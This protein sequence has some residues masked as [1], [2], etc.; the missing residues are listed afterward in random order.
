MAAVL[1]PTPAHTAQDQSPP[2]INSV[3][4]PERQPVRLP[5]SVRYAVR[6][7]HDATGQFTA[8][9]IEIPY[10][11]N[12]GN[13]TN[14]TDRTHYDAF[15]AALAPASTD[16][17]NVYSGTHIDELLEYGPAYRCAAEVRLRYADRFPVDSKLVATIFRAI[18][19]RKIANQYY[20]AQSNRPDRTTREHRELNSLFYQ[21][22]VTLRPTIVAS[23]LVAAPV[24]PT[25]ERSTAASQHGVSA[26][27][28]GV[29]SPQEALPF[30]WPRF[31]PRNTLPSSQINVTAPTSASTAS[32]VEADTNTGGAHFVPL[33]ETVRLSTQDPQLEIVPSAPQVEVLP[34]SLATSIVD[35]SQDHPYQA[36]DEVNSTLSSNTAQP[37]S[38]DVRHSAQP[39]VASLGAV[40]AQPERLLEDPRAFLE[41]CLPQF[42][43]IQLNTQPQLQ[44]HRQTLEAVL[45]HLLPELL[46]DRLGETPAVDECLQE[47]SSLLEEPNAL[48]FV[49]EPRTGP[50]SS[51]EDAPNSSAV[52]CQ[53][54][55]RMNVCASTQTE[56]SPDEASLS[57]TNATD[58]TIS[59][60]CVAQY[61]AAAPPPNSP[62]DISA[63]SRRIAARRRDHSSRL[64]TE[65]NEVISQAVQAAATPTQAPTPG[66]TIA[67]KSAIPSVT[68]PVA[69]I[70]KPQFPVATAVEPNLPS[71]PAPT[72]SAPTPRSREAPID[73]ASMTLQEVNVLYKAENDKVAAEL[74]AWGLPR[75]ET[76]EYKH[77]AQVVRNKYG[78]AVL[79]D[80][81]FETLRTSVENVIDGRQAAA[82]WYVGTEEGHQGFL[83]MMRETQAIL[84]RGP[85]R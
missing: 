53:P 20:A 24:T 62:S 8:M 16:L 64:R 6:A 29:I 83:T 21:L 2:P 79:T 19:N 71:A 65:A 45:R 57:Q 85:R 35:T 70:I 32:S 49:D 74:R 58:S 50:G 51:G 81:R 73:W 17:R 56:A 26:Q 43:L 66:T 37:V 12:L 9:L 67:G 44:G 75:L 30:A 25:I 47:L 22:T 23:L 82:R 77:L 54:T 1:Q 60:P 63:M 61:S 46:K 31:P 55:L 69:S 3:A 52:A 27:G 48:N 68:Q 76:S 78:S 72:V 36:H 10:S 40:G 11:I 4:A 42:L 84:L 41:E 13:S 14:G 39:N 15:I 34:P 28:D 7:Y 59:S 80:R 18:R 5:E 38:I 33:E